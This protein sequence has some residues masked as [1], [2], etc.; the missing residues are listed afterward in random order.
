MRLDLHNDITGMVSRG[1]SIKRHAHKVGEDQEK[2]FNDLADTANI[3]RVPSVIHK[4]YLHVRA[5]RNI[6]DCYEIVDDEN[7]VVKDK[8]S[9]E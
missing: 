2:Y 9:I 1:V 7:F 4:L 3:K 5:N 6:T 8:K